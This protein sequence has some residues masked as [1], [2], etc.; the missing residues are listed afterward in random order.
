METFDFLLQIG[1]RLALNTGFDRLITEL[2]LDKVRV[3]QDR[4]DAIVCGDEVSL[5]RPAPYLIFQAMESRGNQRAS[6]GERGR[7]GLGLGGRLE[8]WRM[9]EYWGFVWGEFART[10]R[11]SCP[12]PSIP[13]CCGTTGVVE[14][15]SQ[16][17]RDNQ[18][19]SGEID[20]YESI[21]P[22]KY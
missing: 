20:S 16:P 1:V 22:L 3:L 10:I 5:G 19:L 9:L 18:Y 2:I 17:Q 12:Y 7:Y 6:G 8:C 11:T 15:G 13:K 4:V 14:V 21:S